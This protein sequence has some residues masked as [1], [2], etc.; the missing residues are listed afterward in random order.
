M[1]MA[2]VMKAW[3]DVWKIP[4]AIPC[5]K[6][7]TTILYSR[8]PLPESVL[9]KIDLK[10]NKMVFKPSGLDLFGEGKDRVLVM[11][12]DAPELIT[13]HEKMIKLGATHDFPRYQPHV[14]ISYDLPEDFNWNTITPPPVFLIPD[15]IYFEP[16]DL[17]W[18]A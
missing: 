16:L 15:R 4:N 1:S 17:D 8:K 6:Y 10:K 11:K 13:L 9:P 18:D 5:E 14:T 3:V 12:L 2:L 7:H